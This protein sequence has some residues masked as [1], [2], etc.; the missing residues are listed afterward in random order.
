MFQ[1]CCDHKCATNVSKSQVA[2]SMTCMSGHVQCQ[3]KLFKS[4]ELFLIFCI[5]LA[6]YLRNQ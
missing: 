2:V 1:G 4:P 3:E 6:F 5:F